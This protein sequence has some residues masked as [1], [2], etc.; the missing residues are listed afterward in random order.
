[1]T[2]TILHAN[3]SKAQIALLEDGRNLP[4]F[5][6]SK[7]DDLGLDP[8]EFRIYARIARRAGKGDAFESVK[9]MAQGCRMSEGKVKASLRTLLSR[10]LVQR[11]SRPGYTTIY[12][13]TPLNEW[14]I[15]PSDV[16][17][18]ITS[19]QP[20]SCGIH[21]CDKK[22]NCHNP[23]RVVSTPQVV[24]CLPPRS[25]EIHPPGRVVSTNDIPQGS[26][27]SSWGELGEEEQTKSVAEEK[28]ALEALPLTDT[29]LEEE[30]EKAEEVPAASLVIPEPPAAA[31]ESSVPASKPTP[32]LEYFRKHVRDRFQAKMPALD[33][34]RLYDWLAEIFSNASPQE[35]SSFTSRFTTAKQARRDASLRY[36]ISKAL[37][38]I[39]GKIEIPEDFS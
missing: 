36:L 28:E 20:R 11:I 3:S 10:R 30:K 18:A 12:R 22:V 16:S 24:S 21:L 5:I 25:P 9:N 33:Q 7:L 6:H 2:S 29:G 8:Y 1:M 4:I 13:L 32:T 15:K 27:P 35:Q 37:P 14:K 23:G 31:A 34:E 17:S 26:S 19:G 38:A 39:R